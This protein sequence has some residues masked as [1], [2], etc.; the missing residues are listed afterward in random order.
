MAE[1]ADIQQ[2]SSILQNAPPRIAQGEAIDE[3]VNGRSILAAQYFC[4]IAQASLPLDKSS[5]FLP[6]LRREIDRAGNVHLQQFVAT[7]IAQNSHQGIVHFDKA[8][9]RRGEKDAFLDGVE[10]F[11]IAL[12]GFAPVGD[13]LKNV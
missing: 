5:Q 12:L 8:P 4:V 3:H 11:A 2:Q 6:L 10:Q 1:T 13:V 7:V 9:V